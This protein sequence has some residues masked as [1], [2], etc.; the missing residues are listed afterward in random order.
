MYCT[1]VRVQRPF[2]CSFVT[3][4]EPIQDLST[5]TD[6]MS[7]RVIEVEDLFSQGYLFGGETVSLV[8]QTGFRWSVI[9]KASLFIRIQDLILRQKPLH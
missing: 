3:L 1:A 8:V 9:L 6:G 5:W 7:S 2:N 4:S